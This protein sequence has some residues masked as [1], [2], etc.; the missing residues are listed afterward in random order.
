[1]TKFLFFVFQLN[2]FSDQCNNFLTISAV[3][4][5]NIVS[6]ILKSN[7]RL[8]P[9][10]HFFFFCSYPFLC[11]LFL[12]FFHILHFLFGHIFFSHRS[13]DEKGTRRKWKAVLSKC[14]NSPILLSFFLS[15]LPTSSY[16]LFFSFLATLLIPCFP[17]SL[18]SLF[19]SIVS[20]F[21]FASSFL[22]L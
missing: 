15:I 1:M 8:S 13:Q 18:L 12:S 7:S 17:Y 5:L 21:Y 3:T 19:F 9:T 2:I 11:Y 22:C 16:S 14:P 6:F 10:R 20:L 4:Y